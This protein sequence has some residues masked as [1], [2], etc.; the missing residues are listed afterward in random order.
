MGVFGES[1]FFRIFVLIFLALVVQFETNTKNIIIRF[2][3]IIIIYTTLFYTKTLTCIVA[4]LLI[5][6]YFIYKTLSY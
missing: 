1:S 3:Y 2:W 6:T 5:I 4:L